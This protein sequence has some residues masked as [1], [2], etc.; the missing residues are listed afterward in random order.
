[1]TREAWNNLLESNLLEKHSL[2]KVLQ[3][4]D[5]FI[6]ESEEPKYLAIYARLAGLL[7]ERE[8][9]ARILVEGEIE[10]GA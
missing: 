8:E 10:D 4:E 1:M 5:V 2:I 7:E 3:D 9:L 6:S